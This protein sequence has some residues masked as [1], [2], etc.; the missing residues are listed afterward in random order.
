MRPRV[1][2]THWVH[3][4]VLELLGGECEVLAVP[5]RTVLP[6][7]EVRRRCRD[8][9]AVIM[10][11][12]DRLDES[13]LEPCPKLVIVAAALK[14]YDNFDVDACTRHGVWFT[15]VPDLL[16]S[17][18]AELAVAL[19]LGL[20]RNLFPG[21]RWVRSGK[22]A[23]WRPTL[24]GNGLGG[25]T[26][27]LVG[28]GQLG[29][30]VARRLLGF[31]VQL[32]YTDPRPLPADE[33]LGRQVSRLELPELLRRS[34]YVVLLTPLTPQ[35]HHLIDR[36][37]LSLCKPTARLINIGRGSVVDEEAVREALDA[38]RLAGYA[39]DVFAMED[40]ALPGCPDSIPQGLLDRMDQTLFTP[41][42]GS[43]VDDV[44]REISLSAA[45]SALQA[46]R[47]DIPA[48]AVN[49]PDPLRHRVVG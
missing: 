2:L 49:R 46:L 33:P 36:R 9:Q 31:E 24:Y 4:E 5:E 47:G 35:T 27:G 23:G 12:A 38:G 8:S 18:T 10:C 7:A 13:F 11:M 20:G 37:W 39:A 40:W 26:V 32:L 48:N 29:M 21:D 28:M 1:V 22:F 17:P 42:L 15:N 44:R 19:L 25:R 43:A 34:D 41:H 30:A 45:Q 16:T 6:A 14:G 3:P